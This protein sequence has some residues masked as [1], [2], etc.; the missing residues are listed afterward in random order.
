VPRTTPVALHLTTAFLQ[1][2]FVGGVLA[3][4]PG[5]SWLDVDRFEYPKEL[6]VHACALAAAICALVA[7]RRAALCKRD[8]LLLGFI[9]LG[10]MSTL[11]APNR[12]LAWRAI[13]VS[14]SSFAVYQ[15]ARVLASR[16]HAMRLFAVAAGGA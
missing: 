6:V 7:A 10:L 1:I 14:I 5:G 2:G 9:G 3:F 4:L 13:A 16:G 12:W 15:A 8:F 11:G